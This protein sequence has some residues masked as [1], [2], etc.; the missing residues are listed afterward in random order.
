MLVLLFSVLPALGA[1]VTL[2]W[3]ASP[4]TNVI[5]YRIYYG[6]SSRAYT[7]VTDVGNALMVTLSNIPPGVTSFYA[8]TAY[9]LAGLESDFS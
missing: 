1:T 3:D 2:A 7:N 9:D 5:G 6:P 4:S 8:A